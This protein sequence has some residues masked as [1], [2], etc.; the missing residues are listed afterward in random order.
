D[1]TD[2]RSFNTVYLEPSLS[3]PLGD[4]YRL[5]AA[6][7]AWVYFGDLEDNPDIGSF[8]GNSGLRLTLARRDGARLETYAQ[9]FLGTG[10]G[11]VQTDLSY[12]VNFGFLDDVNLRLHGQLFAGY[13]D[14]LL[15]YNRQSTRFRLGVSLIP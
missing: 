13:G 4:D 8:R 15:D 12:P 9:G 1:Q 6:P 14:N 3:V 2:S 10:R 11:S 5:T 7:R